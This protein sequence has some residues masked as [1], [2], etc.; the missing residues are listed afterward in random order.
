[1]EKGN[2]QRKK[3]LWICCNSWTLISDEKGQCNDIQEVKNTHTQ[4]VVVKFKNTKNKEQ[5]LDTFKEESWKVFT[6]CQSNVVP[7]NP[8]PTGVPKVGCG[9]GR[10]TLLVQTA[11]FWKSPAVEQLC[12]AA[13]LWYSLAV[14]EH[15]WE[16]AQARQLWCYNPVWQYSSALSSETALLWCC[17]SANGCSSSQGNSLP[18]KLKMCSTKT[19]VKLAYIEKSS[20]PRHWLVCF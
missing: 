6:K 7:A 20:H 13:Q 17:S 9:E 8:M 2:H 4:N 10:E 1:M 19:E 12:E 14:E 11:Q 15:G 18:L 3:K 5:I 16:V